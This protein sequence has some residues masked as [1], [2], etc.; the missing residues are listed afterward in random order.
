MR[1]L[2]VRNL[3]LAAD[4][5]AEHGINALIEPINTRDVPGYFLNRQD[6]AHEIIAEVDRANVKVQMDLYHCQ[7]VEGDVSTKLKTYLPTGNVAH[8]QIASVPERHEPDEG[9][10]NYTYLFKLLNELKYEGWVGCE[11]RPRSDTVKGL[12]WLTNNIRSQ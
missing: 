3:R 6:H 2:Y 7:I 5:F 12:V 10:L 1:G 11:Y 9:E 4:K 8:I